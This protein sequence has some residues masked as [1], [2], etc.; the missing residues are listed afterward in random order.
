MFGLLKRRTSLATVPSDGLGL[1]TSATE[2]Q[3]ILGTWEQVC[4]EARTDV[5]KAAV[6]ELKKRIANASNGG[7]SDKSKLNLRDCTLDD[8]RVN[9]HSENVFSSSLLLFYSKM[10]REE[11]IDEERRDG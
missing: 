4:R 8:R 11:E 5:P 2:F 9:K 7:G 10:M 1:K 6:N 3:K